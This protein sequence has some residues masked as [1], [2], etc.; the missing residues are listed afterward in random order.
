VFKV[1]KGNRLVLASA[2]P[3]RRDFLE[4]LELNFEVIPAE[5]DEDALTIDQPGEVVAKL[6]ELKA[7]KVAAELSDDVS[8]LAADTIVALDGKLFGK[9]QD[10]EHSIAMLRDL[11]GKVHQV[12]GGI[13][14]VNRAKE[15]K[16]VRVVSSDV[17]FY[18]L[19]SKLLK[20]YV[21]SGEYRDKAG[22]YGI[23]G[24]GQLLVKE[25]KGSYS[26][27]VGLDLALVVRMLLENN[28]IELRSSSC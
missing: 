27:I 18:E 16:V 13:A 8:V 7:L 6:A 26:N 14:L 5:I 9:P 10:R 4:S 11:S 25:I 17:H 23:Q 2:S 3:R 24:M 21:D 1:I 28:I 19:D 12:Y 20:S 15:L 22:A